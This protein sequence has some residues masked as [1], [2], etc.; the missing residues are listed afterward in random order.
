MQF[1]LLCY[2]I[3]ISVGMFWICVYLEWLLN[4]VYREH[5][6]QDFNLSEKFIHGLH[7]LVLLIAIGNLCQLSTGIICVC[8]TGKKCAHFVNVLFVV[9]AYI[10]K[11]WSWLVLAIFTFDSVWCLTLEGRGTV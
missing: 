8:S 10:N 5:E 3:L 9:L 1:F 4:T 7:L 11:T 6:T 2:R